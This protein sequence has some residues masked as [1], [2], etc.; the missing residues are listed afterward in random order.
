MK[1]FDSWPKIAIIGN[2]N[3]GKSSLFNILTGLRQ[4]VA[5]LPGVTVDVKKGTAEWDGNA[6]HIIDLPGIYSVYPNAADRRFL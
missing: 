3:S 6:F 1:A 5:N 2:P 4:N